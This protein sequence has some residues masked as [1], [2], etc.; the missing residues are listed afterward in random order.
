TYFSIPNDNWY[1]TAPAGVSAHGFGLTE[2]RV[3]EGLV[4]GLYGRKATLEE[5]VA[6]VIPHIVAE[7][8]KKFDAAS[9]GRSA[10][11]VWRLRVYQPRLKLWP[12][13]VSTDENGVSLVL[14]ATAAAL[15]PT[16]PPSKVRSVAP[17]GPPVSAVPQSTKLEVGVDPQMMGPLTEMLVEA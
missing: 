12:A 6:G 7:L 4:S 9:A 11:R 3:S 14:G 15:D 13:E 1:V 5:K 10:T 2:G 8:E 16:K 17:L